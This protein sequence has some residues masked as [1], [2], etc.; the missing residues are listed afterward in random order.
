MT[1]ALSQLLGPWA[2]RDPED[3]VDLQGLL[4]ET[5]LEVPV[6]FHFEAETRK[7]FHSKLLSFCA[8]LQQPLR[9]VTYSPCFYRCLTLLDLCQVSI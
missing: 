7:E 6:S 9:E 3:L 1:T 8:R 4:V 5:Q 2:E